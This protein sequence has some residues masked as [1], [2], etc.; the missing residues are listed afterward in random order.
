MEN[1]KISNYLF[2]K[3]LNDQFNIKRIHNY[4]GM[5]EQTGSIFLE[6]NRCGF[7]NTHNFSEVIVRDANF[8]CVADGKKG[9]VQLFSILPSSYPGHILLTEDIGFVANKSDC[10]CANLGKRFK[11]VG[12]VKNAELRGCS[13]VQ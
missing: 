2:K 10:S 5:V 8:N 3:K 9:I 12:R 1:I 6:C 11:I 13:D 4:Y 7:F